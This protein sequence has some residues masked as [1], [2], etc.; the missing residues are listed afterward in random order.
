MQETYRVKDADGKVKFHE[1]PVLHG[2]TKG[3]PI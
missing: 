1:S 2:R 3:I